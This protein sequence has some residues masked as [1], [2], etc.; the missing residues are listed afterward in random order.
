MNCWIIRLICEL[1]K[2]K[3]YMPKPF[4]PKDTVSQVHKRWKPGCT[5]RLQPSCVLSLFHT[6][7]SIYPLLIPGISHL[8]INACLI[9]IT[10]WRHILQAHGN[11]LGTIFQSPKDTDGTHHLCSNTV[12]RE[13]GTY[14]QNLCSY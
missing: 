1:V 9:Q 7:F 10:W 13:L 14:F 3:I 11:N 12:E 6:Q 8:F 4:S 5:D 2:P